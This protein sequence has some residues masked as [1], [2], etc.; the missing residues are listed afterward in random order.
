MSAAGRIIV[1]ID[2]Q[3][4]FDHRL[5]GGKAASL[6]R[7]ARAGFRVPASFFISVHG[8]RA[9][10][11]AN[12]LD[13]LVHRELSRRNLDSARWEE[14]WDAALRI[15]TAFAKAAIPQDIVAA[16]VQAM[17][18][19]FG[20]VSLVVR[21]SGVDED[22]A[23][24]SFAGLHDSF[25]D[26][27]GE[28]EFLKALKK[29]WASLW[30]DRA[31]MYRKELDLGIV[32]SAMGVVVQPMLI[33]RASGVVFTRNPH[34]AESM[35]VEAVHGLNPKLIDGE[36]APHRWILGKADGKLAGYDN[37]AGEEQAP[38]K[39]SDLQKLY[40]QAKAVEDL[41][42]CPVDVEFTFLDDTLFILQAR[43]VTT[44]PSKE[45]DSEEKPWDRDDKR[46]WY[47]SLHLSLG[48]LQ[49][50]RKDIEEKY[51][52]AMKK[53]AADIACI[54]PAHMDDGALAKE[55][56]RRIARRDHWKDVYWTFFIPMAHGVRLFAGIYNDALQPDDPYAFLDI[57][58]RG[59]LA[60]LRRNQALEDLAAMVRGDGALQE[61]LA[62][63]DLPAEGAFVEAL[64]AFI[65]QYGMLS[66][67]KGWCEDDR[68]G[69]VHILLETA[70]QGPKTTTSPRDI[71]S[72]ES[73]YFHAFPKEKQA[74]A[75]E[76]L[77]I[78]RA[79]YAMRD[80]DNLLLA[81]FER[82]L[83]IAEAEAKNRLQMRSVHTPDGTTASEVLR[84]L[85]DPDARPEEPAVAEPEKH[86]A[87][88]DRPRLLH[89][90]PASAGV[91]VGKAFVVRD[92][93]DLF[94]FRKGDI[95]VCDSID[96]SMTFVAPLASA[97]VERRGGM[98]VHGAIIAREYGIPCVTGI[99]KAVAI[100]ANGDMLVVDGF[101]GT[102]SIQQ[103]MED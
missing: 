8:Y 47:R 84:L 83:N 73:D 36:A 91:A 81:A 102:V 79:A 52:P 17:Q 65:Q 51:F 34:D 30:S 19:A 4:A 27:W 100:I 103:G 89:G 62:A 6:A 3:D 85:K 39:D 58:R 41:F 46:P 60:A 40:S 25:V 76:V 2:E 11:E 7:L 95:L 26:V 45:A 93:A 55:L 90:Q 43:P 88:A 63:G 80:D 15:K 61:R 82:L 68:R 67:M 10:L 87:D 66:C 48:H 23:G 35:V 72:L 31:L 57:L 18:G 14:L 42:G 92:A 9:F 53:E 78:G 75:R 54:D 21:S 29:V 98:L 33:G 96:P 77:D 64:E 32:E 49:A 16:L 99:D 37:A 1:H 56:A 20:E 71:S 101:K 86:A 97:I 12:G 24:L 94:S 13:E 22:A 44:T 74:F 28:E 69:L 50:L 59:D 5:V 70:K 38:L